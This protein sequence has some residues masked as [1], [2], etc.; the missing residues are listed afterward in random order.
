MTDLF[1]RA[2]GDA[3]YS[4]ARHEVAEAVLRLRGAFTVDALVAEVRSAHD[5]A[6]ATATVYRAVAAMEDSGFIERVGERGGS[7]LYAH[8]EAHS[9]HHHVVCD[10]C[11]R[12]AATPCPLATDTLRLEGPA[13]FVVTRHEVTLYGLCPECASTQREEDC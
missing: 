11:G 6:G 5:A 13:G 12:T 10:Q 4:P 2:Y 9:H 8:C 1:R 3:R 7:A